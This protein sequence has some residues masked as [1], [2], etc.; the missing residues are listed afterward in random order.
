M[1]EYPSVVVLTVFLSLYLGQYIRGR[2]LLFT[3]PVFYTSVLKYYQALLVG[4]IAG[5]FR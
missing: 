4:C 1:P 5:T 2:F 3:G